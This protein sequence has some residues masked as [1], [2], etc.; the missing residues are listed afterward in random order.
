MSVT[1]SRATDCSSGRDDNPLGSATG[2]LSL[3][4]RGMME[5]ETGRISV[6]A[7]SEG[8]LAAHRV[9]VQLALLVLTELLGQCVPGL[10]TLI[11]RRL[12]LGLSGHHRAHGKL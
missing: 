10:G 4:L 5:L 9:S 2:H 7:S 1:E 8:R 3:P 11:H 12:R 6:P